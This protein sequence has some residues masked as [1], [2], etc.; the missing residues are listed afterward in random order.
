M[1]RYEDLE[2]EKRNYSPQGVSLQPAWKLGWIL[3]LR[4]RLRRDWLRNSNGFDR[5]FTGSALA[6]N[7]GKNPARGRVVAL[8]RSFGTELWNGALERS[9]GTE[10]WNGALEQ[11]FGTELWNCGNKALPGA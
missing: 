2:T 3:R 6:W 8:E 10:L 7:E 4:L 11:S 1:A 5:D 9:F